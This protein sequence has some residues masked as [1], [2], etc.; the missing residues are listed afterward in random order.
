MVRMVVL[1]AGF[2]L[3]VAAWSELVTVSQV[4]RVYDGDTIT[5]DI[6]EWPAIVGDDIG[7]RIRGV[8]TPVLRG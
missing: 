1:V 3:P 7:V 8:D 4:V 2:I 6:A 5:V